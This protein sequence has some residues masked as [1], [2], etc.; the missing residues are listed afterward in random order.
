MYVVRP[1]EVFESTQTF[2]VIYGAIQ[3]P[4][5]FGY[6]TTIGPWL[7]A[8]IG[9]P[10]PARV[11]NITCTNL[12]S[13]VPSVSFNKSGCPWTLAMNK[14]RATCGQIQLQFFE[15]QC[16]QQRLCT[17]LH[18]PAISNGA[19]SVT[20]SARVSA[21]IWDQWSSQFRRPRNCYVLALAGR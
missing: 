11:T 2:H 5:S 21:K 19:Y 12:S 17:K 6:C 8:H 7:Y 14:L 16:M 4:L 18:T 20:V 9:E 13:W 15:I 1:F 3:F 10:S